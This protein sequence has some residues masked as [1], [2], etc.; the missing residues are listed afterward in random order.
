M[1]TMKAFATGVAAV[2][3]IGAAAAGVTGASASAAFHIQ[4]VV[5]SAPLP[6][7]QTGGLPTPSQLAG[8]LAGL[9]DPNV[10]FANKSGLV[11][12]GVSPTEAALADRALQK[13]AKKGQLPLSFTVTNVA[14]AGPDAAT[15]DVAVS[16]PK[17]STPVT[18]N[19]TFV[20]QGGWMLSRS[21]A[22]S[23]LQAASGR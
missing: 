14:A 23:L 5:F 16:G 4:P 9:A 1:M 8:V 11:E 3:A 22:M 7:D 2:A 17:L 6:A 19:V 10:P 18:E 21:S 15:A 13:A 20:D 12:G